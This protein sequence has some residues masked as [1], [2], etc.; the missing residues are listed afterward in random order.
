MADNDFEALGKKMILDFDNVKQK[1]GALFASCKNLSFSLFEDT[2][3]VSIE[4]SIAKFFTGQNIITTLPNEMRDAIR[5]LSDTFSIDFSIGGVSKVDIAT[6]FQMEE[7]PVNYYP[8]LWMLNGYDRE[9]IQRKPPTLQFSKGSK[10]NGYSYLKFYDKGNQS[11]IEGNLLRIEKSFRGN[12][13]KHL[14][15]KQRIDPVML[16]SPDFYNDICNSMIKNIESIKIVNPVGWDALP[17][18][19]TQKDFARIA[20]IRCAQLEREIILEKMNSTEFKTPRDKARVKEWMN[21]LITSGMPCNDLEHFKRREELY[22]KIEG[23]KFDY[24]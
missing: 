14:G 19:P 17:K 9:I 21:E 15:K 6:T 3:S 11:G 8:M 13:K 7:P 5:T 23:L 22:S 24:L 12:L 1:R 20:Q 4:G 16:C 10:G 18:N 2:N